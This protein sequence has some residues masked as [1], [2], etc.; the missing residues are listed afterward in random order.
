MVYSF[1]AVL[2][3]ANLCLD[4]AKRVLDFLVHAQGERDKPKFRFNRVGE[5][6]EVL[7]N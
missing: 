7:L 1:Q 3:H 6:F 4:T 5:I 2:I